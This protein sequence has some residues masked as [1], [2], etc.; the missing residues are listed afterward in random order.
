MATELAGSM[1]PMASPGP[2]TGPPAG[3]EPGPPSGAVGAAL[4][5]LP[6]AAG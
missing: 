5:H 4:E 6:D 1:E 3:A 2:A